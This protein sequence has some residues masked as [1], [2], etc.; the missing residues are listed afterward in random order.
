V[1]ELL[2]QQLARHQVGTDG[3]EGVLGGR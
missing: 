2:Q 1:P 3:L